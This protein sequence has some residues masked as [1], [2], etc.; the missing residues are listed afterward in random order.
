[1]CIGHTR[2]ERCFGYFGN[3]VSTAKGSNAVK[4]KWEDGYTS[5]AGGN[6]RSTDEGL[7]RDNVSTVT[8]I[9]W[10]E[11]RLSSL[12]IVGSPTWTPI[13]CLLNRSVGI[14][15]QRNRNPE[16]KA[17]QLFRIFSSVGV[18]IPWSQ[19]EASFIPWNFDFISVLQ[20]VSYCANY[21]KIY[22][23]TWTLNFLYSHAD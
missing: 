6:L 9:E 8:W 17:W 23:S 15:Y 22:E 20:Y 4:L 3:Y 18:T 21:T 14:H 5:W 11:L 2:L 1:M 10:D 12:T 16:G 7:L 13:L 19:N